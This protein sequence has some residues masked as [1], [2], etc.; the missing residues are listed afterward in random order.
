VVLEDPTS[1]AVTSRWLDD[2]CLRCDAVYLLVPS[3][4][5]AEAGFGAL[6]R[7]LPML[8]HSD[9]AVAFLTPFDRSWRPTVGAPAGPSGEPKPALGRV[10]PE[11][12]QAVV[13][14][15]FGEFRGCYEAGLARDPKLE[16]RVVVR[17]V[18]GRDG[19]VSSAEDAGSDLPDAAVVDCVVGRFRAFTFPEPE[20]GIV[21]VV[22]PIH[23]SPSPHGVLPSQFDLVLLAV[24]TRREALVSCSGAPRLTIVVD[25]DGR[26]IDVSA[27]GKATAALS[28]VRAV[29]THLRFPPG[30]GA[31]KFGI[32]P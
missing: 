9:T 32:Q 20:G 8:P 17:F 21:T 18:I 7:L 29:L 2:H 26:V 22:Y 28:C 23:L 13:R 1:E 10:R 6:A 11:V 24:A 16:G 4:Q 3:R 31:R 12:I 30:T 15:R 27:E 25:A 14:R 5:S 19:R